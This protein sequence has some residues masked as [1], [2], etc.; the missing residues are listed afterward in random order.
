MA[1]L[2]HGDCLAVLKTLKANSL[3]SLVTD[4]PAGIGF[5]G[6]DWDHHKGGRDEWVSWL[7][8]VMK[9][10]LR[11]LKPGAHG[12]VWAIPRTSHWTMTA[13]EDAGFEIRDVVTHLFGTGF[14][15]SLDVS[16]AIDRAAGAK[17]K[18]VGERLSPDG[19]PYSARQSNGWVESGFV[20]RRTSD[21]KAFVTAPATAAAK[22]WQGYGTAL[23]PAA[24]FWVLVRKPIDTDKWIV[25][26]TPE[27][28]ASSGF[29]GG[30]CE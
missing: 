11:V 2:H 16:K 18:V 7:T 21:S 12:L 26:L 13:L 25:K 10:C 28:L 6:K 3:D 4:P 5:M 23:K 17:R 30:D 22:Q 24:E 27:V 29:C 15:K 1:D 19:V 8:D 9:Q 20:E 14:P